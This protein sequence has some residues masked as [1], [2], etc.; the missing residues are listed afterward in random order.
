MTPISLNIASTSSICSVL[1]FRG[2]DRV[3]L[4]DRDVA[5]LLGVADQ[6]LNRRIGEVE[7]GAVWQGVG[8]LLLR[9]SFLLGRYLG[10]ACH[11]SSPPALSPRWIAILRHSR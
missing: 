7:Q 5:A 2:Q 8:T 4:V 11:K 10:L 9:R 3:D 1:T 6:P